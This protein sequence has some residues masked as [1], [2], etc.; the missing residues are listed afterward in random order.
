[1]TYYRL[2]TLEERLESM[3]RR[4]QSVTLNYGEE[5]NLWECSWI[6]GGKRYTTFDK[7]PTVAVA[8]C[9]DSIP[10]QD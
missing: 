1:M 8:K 6:T 2:S 9:L 3:A 10:V 7:S 5:D 4:G